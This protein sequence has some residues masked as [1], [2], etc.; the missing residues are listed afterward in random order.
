MHSRMSR[1][2]RLDRFHLFADVGISGIAIYS[3]IRNPRARR[4]GSRAI[5]IY[6]GHYRRETGIG[7]QGGASPADLA[8]ACN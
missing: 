7:N 4:A 3:E 2:A 1:A 8:N 6:D 5:E